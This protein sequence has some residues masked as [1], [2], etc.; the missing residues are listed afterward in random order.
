[1]TYLKITGSLGRGTVLPAT[2]EGVLDLLSDSCFYFWSRRRLGVVSLRHQYEGSYFERSI[3]CD[4]IKLLAAIRYMYIPLA[5]W[6]P[7][8]FLPSHVTCFSPGV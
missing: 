3:L 1:M 5:T 8:R 4:A 6:I 7:F 2:S